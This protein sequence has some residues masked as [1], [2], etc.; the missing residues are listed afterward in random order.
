MANEPPYPR[1]TD[2]NGETVLIVEMCSAFGFEGVVLF[3][4]G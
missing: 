2:R 1:S 3:E 4:R